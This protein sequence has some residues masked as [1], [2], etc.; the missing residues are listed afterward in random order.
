MSV[1]GSRSVGIPVVLLH[2]GEGMTVTVEIKSGVTY[3]GYLHLAEDNMNLHMRN[4]TATDTRGKQ[5]SLDNL[6][7]R[8]DHIRFIIFPDIYPA[9]ALC[10]CGV[11]VHCVF[12]DVCSLH[13]CECQ[14]P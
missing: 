12:A 8:G 3:R 10:C 7:I 14:P 9:P 6:Y 5:T 13:V 2:E 4:V 1:S 11:V